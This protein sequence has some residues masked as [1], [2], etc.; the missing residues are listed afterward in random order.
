MMSV[1]ALSETFVRDLPFDI[2]TY[3][4]GSLGIFQG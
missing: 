2:D 1:E 4:R 3:L